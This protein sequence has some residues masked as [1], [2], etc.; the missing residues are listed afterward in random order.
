MTI[1]IITIEGNAGGDGVLRNN[2]DGSTVLGLNVAV[3]DPEN[4]EQTN[5]YRCSI[6]GKRAVSLQPYLLK[7]TK[8][9]IVGTMSIGEYE[10]KPQFKVR[11]NDISFYNPQRS[12]D[13]QP[14]QQ[15]QPTAHDVAKQNGYQPQHNLDDDV[16]F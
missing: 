11:V 1:Q 5:W 9:Y 3:K 16:P 14:S 15:R 12:N 4:K 6:W 8:V 7:G 10:G 13:A 2:A